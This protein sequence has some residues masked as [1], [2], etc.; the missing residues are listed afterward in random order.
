MA[1]DVPMRGARLEEFWRVSCE[2]LGSRDAGAIASAWLVLEAMYHHPP[3]AYH[4]MAHIAECVGELSA[5]A[6][7]VTPIETVAL[8]AVALYTHDCVYDS[9]RP[10]NEERS[11]GVAV[12]LGRG[13]GLVNWTL[14]TLHRL[15]MA[16]THKGTPGDAGEALIRDVDLVSL[17]APEG[18]FDANTAAI[19]GEYAWAS[20]A[21][22][23]TGRV[24]FF[25]EILARPAIYFTPEFHG[26]FEGAARANVER[27]LRLMVG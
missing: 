9:T 12:A 4:N 22:W 8:V 10:D 2:A 19:R 7:K 11:A 14:G 17:A 24:A 16:T 25:R 18:R 6:A 15:V 5:V 21:Q 26:R 1:G 23:R 20:D 3:R 13:M 27:A